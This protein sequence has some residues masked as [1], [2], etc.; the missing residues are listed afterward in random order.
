MLRGTVGAC[1]LN[2]TLNLYFFSP[3]YPSLSV[4]SV[5]KVHDCGA[6]QWSVLGPV[7]LSIFINDIGS[8]TEC[9]LDK[10]AGNT[11]PNGAVDKIGR[12]HV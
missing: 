10:F 12:A 1:D 2:C 5:V 6:S 4:Y 7:L 11:K 3:I 9:T 8:G